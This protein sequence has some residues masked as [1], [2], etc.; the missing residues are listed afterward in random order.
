MVVGVLIAL[1]FALSAAGG[2]DQ[3]VATVSATHFALFG[4][5]GPAWAFGVFFPT[6]FL[7]LG[8]SSMYQKFFSAKD[9]GSA[10]RAVLG[11]VVGVVIIET[12]L[13]LLAVI[14]A[15]KYWNLAPF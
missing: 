13:A 4:A 5:H 1:P 14:G 11:M 8:V 2:W 9:E 6:F 7:R 15:G 3:V 12:A 10:R